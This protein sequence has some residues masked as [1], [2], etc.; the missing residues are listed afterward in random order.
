MKKKDHIRILDKGLELV[1]NG[2]YLFLTG[3]HYQVM[4][5]CFLMIFLRISLDCKLV[6]V[7]YR[8]YPYDSFETYYSFVV[9]KPFISKSFFL[10]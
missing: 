3:A 5:S 6:P 7:Q 8:E 1:V 9:A 4:G 2:I 10:Q